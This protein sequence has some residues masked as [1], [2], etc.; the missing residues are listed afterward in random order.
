MSLP[1]LGHLR[2][3]AM[4]ISS[5][6]HDFSHLQPQFLQMITLVKAAS[7]TV[8]A[9]LSALVLFIPNLVSINDSLDVLKQIQEACI[10]NCDISNTG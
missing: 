6:G 7:L 9:D 8:G 5:D 4:Q 10:I 1:H 3:E 2:I